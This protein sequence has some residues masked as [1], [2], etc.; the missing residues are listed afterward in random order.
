MPRDPR[1]N[2]KLVLINQPQFSKR[3][4][5][6]HT[7]QKQPITALARH[8]L[9]LL[10]RLPQLPPHKFR[11]PINLSERARHHI[12]LRRINGASK[13]LHPVLHPF[14]P[15]PIRRPS[16]SRLH[17]LISHPPKQQRIRPRKFLRP[18]PMQFRI[19]GTCAEIATT[20][21]SDVDG[22]PK[23]SH[24][25]RLPPIGSTRHARGRRQ[26]L[27]GIDSMKIPGAFIS[28]GNIPLPG[29]ERNTIHY[30]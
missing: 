29:D 4:R 23:G 24:A 21:H 7:P 22:I 20:V 10:N 28:Y 17:H 5:K 14:R 1:L 13:R 18:E 12:F 16:P 30:C 26:S 8:R 3:Q 25:V 6:F 19:R 11:V 27:A 2:D 15:P 9:K